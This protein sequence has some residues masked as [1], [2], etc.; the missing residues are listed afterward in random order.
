MDN[1]GPPDGELSSY[2]EAAQ[3]SDAPFDAFLEAVL[4]RDL[5]LYPAQEEA[6]LEWYSGNHVFL[7]TPTGS[8]KSLVALSA[9]FLA[10]TEGK[11]SFY[12]C[13]IKALVSEKFFSLCDEFGAENVGMLTGDVSLNRD[14]P[15]ICC[16]A[17]ILANIAIRPWD[18]RAIDVVIMDEFHYYSDKERGVAW[19]VPLLT[20]PQTQFMLMSATMGRTAA[21]E[22]S[23]TKITGRNCAF[24]TSHERPVP[25]D[26]R[27][28]DIP[29]HRAVKELLEE[30]LA[31]VYIVGFTQRNC[32]DRAQDMMSIDVSSKAEKAEIKALLKGTRFDSPYGK[33]IS[34]FLHHGIGLHHAGLLPKYRLAVE[35]LAKRGLLRLICGTDTLGVGINIPLK[36]VLFTQ[37]FKFNGEDNTIL[38]VRD[39]KQIAGRAGRRGFDSHGYVVAQAPEHVIENLQAERRVSAN[40]TKKRKVVKKKPPERN[41]VMWDESTFE[42]L[43]TSLSEPL[44]SQ[45]KVS[46][47]LLLNAIQAATKTETRGYR[48]IVELIR[49]SHDRHELQRRHIRHAAELVRSLREA[50]IVESR[51]FAEGGKQLVLKEGMQDDFSL[52]QVLSLF[53]IQIADKI[54][55]TS[56][57]PTLDLI[58]L[59]ESVLENPHTILRQQVAHLKTQLM[60]EMKA[61]GVEYDERMEKLS[62]VEHPKPLADFLYAHYNEFR[63]SHPWIAEHNVRP[64][65]VAREMYEEFYAFND[66]IRLYGLEKSE[67]QLLRYLSEFYKT[68]QQTLPAGN[69]DEELE[70]CLAYFRG[71][72]AR[73][74]S[75]LVQE[76][77]R[78]LTPKSE[79]ESEDAAPEPTYY[80]QLMADRKKCAARIRTDVHSFLREFC[81]GRLDEATL[82]L[83]DEN[84]EANDA[85]AQL[86]SAMAEAE[87][88]PFFGHRARLAQ[89]HQLRPTAPGV[90]EV[91]QTVLA[92]DEDH[93]FALQFEVNLGPDLEP[94][95]PILTLTDILKP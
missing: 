25:L 39:F 75:S 61:A 65:S 27:F 73:V 94:D 71:V 62:Q 31:P 7:A 63:S 52:H 77:E 76:W 59:F 10:M 13:P 40:P 78:R 43:Q 30:G 45:F 23:L 53:A 35:K 85:L 81:N 29:L 56:P 41:F 72:L 17:E 54:Q 38:S 8:G 11:R 4:E 57:Q 16:T 93:G 37:L 46:H 24:I 5:E 83:T 84:T 80:D 33:T 6:I 64:K 79:S 50:G 18:D 87:L 32:A 95:Q 19:Q 14:A 70:E 51:A 88:K 86:E 15:I 26:Y 2:L 44:S 74:D 3:G 1:Q 22:A 55:E 91:I 69:R 58:S 28:S 60:D 49:E 34:R 67:G 9:H 68:L 82:L 21:L 47:G 92:D 12:T 66:Y 90:F 42:R 20:M 36:T 89:F 48:R